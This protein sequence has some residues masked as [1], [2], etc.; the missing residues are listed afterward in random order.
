MSNSSSKANWILNINGVRLQNCDSSTIIYNKEAK[1]AIL[2][3]TFSSIEAVFNGTSNSVLLINKQTSEV[4]HVNHN[5]DLSAVF[6]ESDTSTSCKNLQEVVDSNKNGLDGTGAMGIFSLQ[7]FI[8]FI[9]DP[10]GFVN[11][12]NPMTEA[13]HNFG[14][15]IQEVMAQSPAGHFD[16]D[17]FLKPI[18]Q[19]VPNLQNSIDGMWIGMQNAFKWIF[20]HIDLGGMVNG[21]VNNSMSMLNGINNTFHVIPGVSQVVSGAGQL[22]HGAGNVTMGAVAQAQGNINNLTQ[23]MGSVWGRPNGSEGFDF[24]GLLHPWGNSTGGEDNGNGENSGSGNIGG[25]AAISGEAIG[26]EGN[27]E[28]ET[29]DG[30]VN[31]GAVSSNGATNGS[32]TSGGGVTSNGASGGTAGG[33]RHHNGKYNIV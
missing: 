29:D 11:N 16:M 19:F 7:N 25:S 10:I 12:P 21:M 6:N 33:A 26:E 27:E 17:G 24:G 30:G 4:K 23:A 8:N 32:G 3:E 14:K 5:V 15:F 1:I 9:K 18:T 22:V 20:P 13:A 31:G 2:I 28:G